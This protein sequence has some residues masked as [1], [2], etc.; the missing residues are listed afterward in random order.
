MA[1]T[2]GYQ[3]D[4]TA[5]SSAGGGRSGSDS[6]SSGFVVNYGGGVLASAGSPLPAWMWL[7]LAV[8][9]VWLLR[10]HK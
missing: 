3:L 1:G 7:A 4:T 2:V 9:G 10:K 6:N 5:V 8:G